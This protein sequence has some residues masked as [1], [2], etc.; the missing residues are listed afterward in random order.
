MF[1]KNTGDSGY[2]TDPTTVDRCLPCWAFSPGCTACAG[3]SSTGPVVTTCTQCDY[4]GDGDYQKHKPIVPK[5][6]Y[7]LYDSSAENG[8]LAQK[9]CVIDK[10]ADEFTHTY[11]GGDPN[12]ITNNG[13]CQECN[14]GATAGSPSYC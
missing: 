8:G 7:Y 11:S 12:A 3:A 10:C 13:E 5:K 14:S 9:K 1:K 2:P 4:T 6:K